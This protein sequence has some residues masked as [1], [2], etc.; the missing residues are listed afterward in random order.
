MAL[1]Y[2]FFT[3][4]EDFPT[5]L[6]R[7]L[8]R[9]YSACTQGMIEKALRKRFIRIN[10]VKQAAGTL[11]EAGD[12]VGVEIHLHQEWEAL[13][14]EAE[15]QAAK[16]VS[17]GAILD[18]APLIVDETPEL[19]ILNKPSGMN[20]QGGT[21][22]GANLADT[23][24]HRSKECRLVH[25]IDRA[26]SGLLIVAKTLSAAVFLT[27]LFRDHK[28][29]KT[30][31]AIVGGRLKR[32]SG[33]INSP[34]VTEGIERSAQTRYRVVAEDPKGRWTDVELKP[35]TGRK[36]QLRIHM[37]SLGHPIVGDRKYDSEAQTFGLFPGTK[38]LF[39]H[40]QSLTF[41]DKAGVM[42]TWTVSLPKYWPV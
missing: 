10:G 14:R 40:A 31:R 24:R 32:P 2:Q 42:Q 9:Q 21:N 7:W 38:A 1:T 16:A 34:I 5:R 4:S 29:R 26:T 35:L 37:A 39:L 6:D 28:V 41:Q 15:K 36:H 17:S 11:L 27:G 23:L 8:R 12:Q 33:V 13:S 25:R 3:Y 30:Y 18:L 19:L 20:V 22:V